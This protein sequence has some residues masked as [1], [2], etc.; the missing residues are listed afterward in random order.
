[1]HRSSPRLRRQ[2]RVIMHAFV[3]GGVAC[4]GDRGAPIVGPVT[5][6]FITAASVGGT[7]A[8]RR[9]DSP[10]DPAA[11]AQI[12]VRFLNRA[13]AGGT[14]LIAIQPSA[15]IAR[16]VLAIE[17]T[18]KDYFE[19]VSP[20]ATGG[21]VLV[22][23]VFAAKPSSPAFNLRIAAAGTAQGNVGEYAVLPVDLSPRQDNPRIGLSFTALAFDGFI[24]LSPPASQSVAITN[25]G[26]GAL[27]RLSVGTITFS[28]STAPWLSASLGAQVAPTS[29]TLRPST[30][31]LARGTYTATVPVISLAADASPR[32]VTVTYQVGTIPTIRFSSDPVSVTASGFSVDERRTVQI[33]NSGDGQLTG[34][35]IGTVE[36]DREPPRWLTVSLSSTTAPT[37]LSVRVFGVGISNGTYTASVPVRSSVPNVAAK[38]LRVQFEKR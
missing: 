31:A 6:Q 26:T 16:I 9:A 4:G 28:P 11:G 18:A 30:T 19:I 25:T 13:K 10:P 24:G 3:I 22:S 8:T 7:K 35:S 37:T 29:L 15:P 38:T 32:P 17:G 14:G 2:S 36:Y 12:A 33:T 21:E 23:V 27:D 34:L 1:M 5:Q 20:A